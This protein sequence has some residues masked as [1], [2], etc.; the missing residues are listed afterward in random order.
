MGT[1]KIQK[2]IVGGFD[3]DPDLV[4]AVIDPY[5]LYGGKEKAVRARPKEIKALTRKLRDAALIVSEMDR[6]LHLNGGEVSIATKVLIEATHA[7]LD[8]ATAPGRSVNLGLGHYAFHLHTLFKLYYG[9]YHPDLVLKALRQKQ[10]NG[11]LTDNGRGTEDAW[12]RNIVKRHRRL[13]SD[14]HRYEIATFR[15]F[16]RYRLRKRMGENH[17]KSLNSIFPSISKKEDAAFWPDELAVHNPDECSMCRKRRERAKRPPIEYPFKFR[18][19]GNLDEYSRGQFAV[20]LTFK[21]MNR[22][23]AKLRKGDISKDLYNN[24]PHSSKIHSK[25]DDAATVLEA[26]R[27]IDSVD[28]YV[29]E[30]CNQQS[31]SV[32]QQVAATGSGGKIRR[33]VR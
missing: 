19:S 13:A 24:F 21:L 23:K 14:T 22:L 28:D 25:L 32:K 26:R 6:F 12:V 15:Y 29:A 16:T 27:I 11:V 9:K 2:K 18:G 3:L 10:V 20:L 1:S 17:P 33:I 31:S 5:L 8:L 30:I 4:E 7:L